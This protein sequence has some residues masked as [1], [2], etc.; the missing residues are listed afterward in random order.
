VREKMF[1]L[2][3]TVNIAIAIMENHPDVKASSNGRKFRVAEALL[4]ASGNHLHESGRVV[5]LTRTHAFLPQ[6][7]ITVYDK[8]FPDW[9]FCVG[10]SESSKKLNLLC[11]S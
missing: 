5:E 1:Y 7:K 10:D 6:Y 9:V 4:K 8:L 3:K 2:A 11:D